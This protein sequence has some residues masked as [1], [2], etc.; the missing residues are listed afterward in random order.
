LVIF[1]AILAQG[2]ASGNDG[3]VALTAKTSAAVAP[4]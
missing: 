3:L 4:D 1:K 2:L